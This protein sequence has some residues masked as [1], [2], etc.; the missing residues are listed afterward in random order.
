MVISKFGYRNIN[1]LIERLTIGWYTGI[2][3]FTYTL[4]EYDLLSITRKL[5]NHQRGT[6]CSA[7]LFCIRICMRILFYQ[8]VFSSSKL[9][10][11]RP[12]VGR[13]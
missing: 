8:E 7:S 9:H 1:D 13:C 2:N 5:L 10:V 4:A 3:C 6:K 12:V 11:N